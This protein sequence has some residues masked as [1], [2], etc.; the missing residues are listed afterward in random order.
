MSGR[1]ACSV[2]TVPATF[3]SSNEPTASAP[4]TSIGPS[5][6]RPALHTAGREAQPHLPQALLSS[7]GLGP[8]SGHRVRKAS[9]HSLQEGLPSTSTRPSVTRSRAAA[10]EPASLT[11]SCNVSREPG[12]HL[13]DQ[14]ASHSRP[15]VFRSRSVAYTGGRGRGPE[16]PAYP[17]LGHPGPGATLSLH[18]GPLMYL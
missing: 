17:Y 3:T 10:M 16:F 4:C 14:A 18:P 11:S 8:C 6:P 2:R 12:G 1:K 15:C 5:R 9:V 7:L 13:R